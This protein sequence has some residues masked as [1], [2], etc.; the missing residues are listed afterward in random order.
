MGLLAPDFGLG[1]LQVL[2]SQAVDGFLISM[3]LSPF[4]ITLSLCLSNK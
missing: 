3:S 1:Q 2:G 4:P